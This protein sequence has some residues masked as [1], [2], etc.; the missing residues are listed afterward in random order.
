M[1]TKY[2]AIVVGAGQAGLPLASRLSTAGWTVAL[3]ERNK[4]GGTCVNVGCTPT[5]AL[6]ASAQAAHIARR[7]IDFG[8][9][10]SN[11]IEVDM[12]L[13][14][15]RMDSIVGQSQRGVRGW[16]DRMKGVTEYTGTAHFVSAK[17]MRVG[18]QLLE[19]PKIFLNVGARPAHPS[20]EGISETPFLNSSSILRLDE[21][22]GHLVVIGGGYIGLEFAQM[23]RRFGSQVTVVERS[24]RILPKLDSDVSSAVANILKSEGIRLEVQAECIRVQVTGDGFSAH[25]DC[26]EGKRH[27]AGTHI[28]MA[29]GRTPNTQDLRL[30]LAGVRTD[31]QGYIPVDDELRTNVEGIW[32][33][34]DCNR[35]GAFTHT[36][37]NDFE[38]VA[39]TS[40]MTIAVKSPI[41]SSPMP[42]TSTPRSRKLG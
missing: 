38:I 33:L 19:A 31:P 32:A 12:T 26:P 10:L 35:R 34:G 7:A 11:P 20:I 18:D 22:P 3:V 1:S 37:Y 42:F 14:R 41:E 9:I 24:S 8:I 28:L 40:W 30:Q 27:V 2:D 36:S 13:V 15:N 25:L 5:K 6:V 21:L 29:I 16:L 4:L 23:Y 39:A 17:T